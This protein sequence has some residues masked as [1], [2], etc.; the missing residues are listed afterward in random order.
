MGQGCNS[1]WDQPAKSWSLRFLTQVQVQTRPKILMK[2]SL[3]S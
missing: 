3:C 2:I 1:V